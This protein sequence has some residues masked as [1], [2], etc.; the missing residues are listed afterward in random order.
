VAED[1]EAETAQGKAAE[2]DEVPVIGEA[3][4]GRILA[5]RSNDGAIAHS[6]VTQGDR[7]EKQGHR[8]RK[9]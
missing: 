7:R 9:P 6:E 5:H 2:M 4:L 1:H 3:V 8:G